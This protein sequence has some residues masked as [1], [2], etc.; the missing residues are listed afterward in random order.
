M[1][2][3]LLAEDNL[4]KKAQFKRWICL[5]RGHRGQ[6]YGTRCCSLSFGR[7][8]AT[9]KDNFENSYKRINFGFSTQPVGGI[10]RVESIY[11]DKVATDLLVFE[12]PLDTVEYLRLELPA[13]NFGGSGML[14]IQIPKEMIVR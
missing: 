9:L 6:V 10:E 14:R 4:H 3:R 11:P 8:F 13:K 12:I 5:R 2:T 7:D 1:G